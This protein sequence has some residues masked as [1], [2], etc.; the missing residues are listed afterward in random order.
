MNSSQSFLEIKIF[1]K[2]KGRSEDEI[3]RTP[4]KILGNNSSHTAV[5]KTEEYEYLFLLQNTCFDSFFLFL[6]Y[7]FL[8]SCR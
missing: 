8:I 2:L 5:R 1:K 7:I 3:L 4:L 6:Y